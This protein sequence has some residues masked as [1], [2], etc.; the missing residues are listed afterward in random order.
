MRSVVWTDACW[1]CELYGD[2][3]RSVVNVWMMLEISIVDLCL[4]KMMCGFVQWL[5][6]W[7]LSPWSSGWTILARVCVV[8]K[9]HVFIVLVTVV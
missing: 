6:R 2:C 3:S 8:Q 9:V 4:V 7:T 1:V 5:W